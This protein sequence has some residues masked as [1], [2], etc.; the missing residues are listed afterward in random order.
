MNCCFLNFVGFLKKII[1]YF[2]EILL[3]LPKWPSDL[4]LSK[5]LGILL[6]CVKEERRPVLPSKL[7]ISHFHSQSDSLRFVVPRKGNC[8][9]TVLVGGQSS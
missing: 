7:R 5:V 1:Y 4:S 3:C 6:S 2:F 9:S 8:I